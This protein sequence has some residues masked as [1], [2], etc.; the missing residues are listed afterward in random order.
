MIPLAQL[1]ARPSVEDR[2][3]REFACYTTHGRCDQSDA[4]GKQVDLND[5]CRVKHEQL[6]STLRCEEIIRFFSRSE[7]QS[8]VMKAVGS[9]TWGDGSLVWHVKTDSELV[10]I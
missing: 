8:I 4:H 5:T 7:L 6:K 9:S 3:S 1:L 2:S 10:G